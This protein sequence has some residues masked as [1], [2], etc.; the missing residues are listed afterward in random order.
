MRIG[1]I[2]GG[3]AGLAAAY[4]LAD[5]GANVT[6]FEKDN[7]LGGLAGV[8]KIDNFL[9]EKYYHHIFTTDSEIITLIQELGLSDRL[10]WLDSRMGLYY[11]NKIHPF[12]TPGELLRFRYLS[13]F[14]K[15]R[16]GATVLFLRNYNNWKEL[17]KVTAVEWMRK[18]AGENVCKVIW[19]PLLTAKF[20][21]NY[22]RIS[23]AWLWG[24]IKL[25]GSSRSKGGKKEKL[26]YLIGSFG[27]IT[28]E[29]EKKITNKG[30][31]VKKSEQV[32]GINSVKNDKIYI[33][34]DK[35]GYE[36]DRVISTVA[37]PILTQI[38]P[39][40]PEEYA[41]KIRQ[42]EY[43][44]TVCVILILK[45]SFTYN[46]WENIS[47]DSIP[48]GGVIE[49]TNFILPSAYNNKNILYIS[50]YLYRDEWLYNCSNTDLIEEYSKHLKKMNP[51]FSKDWIENFFIFHDEFAQPI[52]TINYSKILPDF[53][54]PI[55][56]L[57]TAT[58]AQI[59]PED[60][61]MNYSVKLGNR[62]AEIV[63]HE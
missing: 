59:Y 47:D 42:I 45:K 8:V 63:L 20:G 52:V 50:N 29:L 24:K 10:T 37:F 55:K 19:E 61:G 5:K 13:L 2:G 30:S 48:F 62:I 43:A 60:R 38:T 3:I 31:L 17:E 27:Q 46:Y 11:E 15:L 14:D 6:L 40:L 51:N 39:Q 32:G 12:G 16:F 44:S 35:G 36:F 28:D 57:F 7:S 56:N 33:N 41:K 58:M 21:K 49:H 18:Y 34:T 26:G 22:N 9:I 53:R 23:M 4:R 54:T 1:I 25:R